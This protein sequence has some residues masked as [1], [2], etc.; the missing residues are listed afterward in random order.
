MTNN[1]ILPHQ[2]GFT[3]GRSCSTQLLLAMNDWTKTLDDGHSV[4]I[5]YFDFAKAF[6]SVPHN[7]LISKLQGCGISGKL[8]AWVKNFL[9]G[10]KQK[11]VLNSHASD[12]SS[13]SSGVPQG[14]VLD[15]ILFNIYV[16]DMPLIVNSPIFQ[17]ADD[18][19]M[20]RTIRTVDDF[21]QLQQDINLLFAWSKK[22]QL[23]FNISKCN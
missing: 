21:C 2:H 20:F 19:K 5:L 23:K 3:P 17:F 15:P 13:V 10:R 16:S 8:L 9:V 14:S 6:D 7:R 1:V 22:W 12:W 18:V 4:D 11:V